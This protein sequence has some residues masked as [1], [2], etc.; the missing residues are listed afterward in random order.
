MIEKISNITALKNAN[1]D[2]TK[3]LQKLRSEESKTA[4]ITLK[5]RR[6][7][8][9]EVRKQWLREQEVGHNYGDDDDLDELNI[10]AHDGQQASDLLSL[11][12]I[13]GG[14][15]AAV[16]SSKKSCQCGSSTHLRTSHLEC[17]L[18]KINQV[19]DSSKATKRSCK[20]GSTEHIRTNHHDCPFNKCR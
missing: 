16:V 2:R 7:I 12:T 6:E 20:C 5:R 15:S 8:E 13:V 19:S 3:K 11:T 14:S 1:E 10:E 17:P 4:R 9:Q 18:N